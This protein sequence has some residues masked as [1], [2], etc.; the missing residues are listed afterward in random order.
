[1]R[2]QFSL[3]GLRFRITL[4]VTLA[5][6]VI[7]GAFVAWR[8]ARHSDLDL[9]E[10]R[11]QTA[12]AGELI[13]ASLQQA[14]LMHDGN[15]VKSI[16]EN[17]SRQSDVRGIYLLNA[18]DELTYYRQS[19]SAGAVPDTNALAA[20]LR[21]AQTSADGTR[22]QIYTATTGEQLLRN[23]TPIRNASACQSCHTGEQ[24]VLGTLISDFALTETNYQ[25][26]SDLQGSITAGLVTLLAV[27]LSVNLLLS[28]FILDKLE[29]FLPALQ[30]FGQGD[31]SLR[32][33]PHG[34]DEI[35]QLA[36][37]FNQMADSLQT[38]E[39][40][41]ARLY[42][43]LE[44]KEAARAYLLGQVIAAQEQEHKRL[45]RELHDDF[46]QSLT[47]LSV[48][49]QSAVETIPADMP[50]IHDRLERVLQ[51]TQNTLDET[52]RW[53]QDLRPRML[54]DLGLLPAVR[55]FAEGRFEGTGTR[56]SLEANNLAGHLPPEVEITLFRVIQ[57]ALSN[58]AKHA[59]ACR[60][61]IRIDRYDS[62]TLV[63][64]VTDD[65]IGFIPA[66]YLHAQDGLRGMG[67]LGMRERVN[68]LGGTL[69]LDSTPGRGTRLRAE[70]PCKELV[71]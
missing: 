3:H 50:A 57:E 65:G 35:G 13:T 71:P 43:E 17:V 2:F 63:A 60:V 34:A 7:L 21:S 18:A 37:G 20:W 12:V 4:A 64:H 6:I 66:R 40:D 15:D 27:V 26:T 42:N 46:A 54:D 8:Y 25:L 36:A 47:A 9:E 70:V 68:L 41:N 30:R 44:R 32:L 48:T 28:R 5:L 59:H 58:V 14:M 52:S 69:M 62:G 29:Q 24:A 55:S 16:I 38:R 1:M 51:L 53:I 49:V 22:G 67:L 11:A 23:A 61:E 19:T 39:R 33:A 45:A 10:A 31:L 56:V